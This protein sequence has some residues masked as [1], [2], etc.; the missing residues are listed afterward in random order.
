MLYIINNYIYKKIITI[1]LILLRKKFYFNLKQLENKGKLKFFVLNVFVELFNVSFQ[2][3]ILKFI[4][5]FNVLKSYLFLLNK[6]FSLKQKLL[7]PV[8]VV[9]NKG[10]KIILLFLLLYFSKEFDLII[11]K[12]EFSVLYVSIERNFV[13]KILCFLFE[14][15]VDKTLF[16]FFILLLNKS[17]S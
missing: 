17:V 15:S 1:F 2:E 6:S 8:L 13:E 7:S 3:L 14:L 5:S 11:N 12:E 16:F 10:Q 9:Y 4:F